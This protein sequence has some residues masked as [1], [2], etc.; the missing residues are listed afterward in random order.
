MDFLRCNPEGGA[1][2]RRE[3][4]IHRRDAKGAEKKY[5]I[6]RLRRLT[7]I[8]KISIILN[9]DPA[10]LSAMPRQVSVDFHRLK[11]SKKILQ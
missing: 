8:K 11:E 1:V 9:A 6:H 2:C 10:S 4:Y 7:Q 5:K 3:R